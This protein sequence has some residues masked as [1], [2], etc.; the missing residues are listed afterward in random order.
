[1]NREDQQANSSENFNKPFTEKDSVRVS[2]LSEALPYIQ[3]FANIRI[4][5]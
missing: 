1:M 5:I 4:V 3:R 2:V